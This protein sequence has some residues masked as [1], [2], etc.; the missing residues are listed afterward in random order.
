MSRIIGAFVLR[1]T[2]TNTS[3]VIIGTGQRG[4]GVD[5]EIARGY[6]EDQ[7]YIPA[8]SLTGVLRHR[9]AGSVPN[10]SRLRY[11]WGGERDSDCQSHFVIEDL[12]PEAGSNPS[13]VV[14]D[15]IKIDDKTGQVKTGAK[16]A[17]EVL[18]P[19]RAFASMP[20]PCYGK[21]FRRTY[22]SNRS[23]G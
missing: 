10:T 9:I 13:V 3:P 11:F 18:D 16:F 19:G 7:P 12:I 23:A 22:F 1:G 17:S 8:T 15:G 2:V 21:V 5:I 6:A 20:R 14:R 4:E